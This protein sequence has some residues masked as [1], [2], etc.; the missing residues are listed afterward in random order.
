M[1]RHPLSEPFVSPSQLQMNTESDKDIASLCAI[2]QEMISYILR[3]T[4]FKDK[5]ILAGLQNDILNNALE[6]E[7]VSFYN[8]VYRYLPCGKWF[9]PSETKC[10]DIRLVPE[11]Q[12]L[13]IDLYSNSNR[14]RM[15]FNKKNGIRL[16]RK[17]RPLQ[18][19]K[20]VLYFNKSSYHLDDRRA[21]KK[22]NSVDDTYTHEWNNRRFWKVA[23]YP[24]RRTAS[25]LLFE[26][27]GHITGNQVRIAM[28]PATPTTAADFMTRLQSGD[29]DRFFGRFGN[30][31]HNART[32][33]YRSFYNGVPT[34]V[35]NINIVNFTVSVQH[36]ANLDSD[37]ES[38]EDWEEI[39]YAVEDFKKTPLKRSQISSLPFATKNEIQEQKHLNCTVKC[40][41]TMNGTLYRQLV[42]D[43]L[44]RR[45]Y[46]ILKDFVVVSVFYK[47][48]PVALSAD[49]TCHTFDR[50]IHD[51][52]HEWKSRQQMSTLSYMVDHDPLFYIHEI[53][54]LDT[55]ALPRQCRNV[56]INRSMVDALRNECSDSF[57]EELYHF[58]TLLNFN[59]PKLAPL[60]GFDVM[61]CTRILPQNIRLYAYDYDEINIP[62]TPVGV[63]LEKSFGPVESGVIPVRV[64]RGRLAP[65]TS[66]SRILSL[67]NDHEAELQVKTPYTW[68]FDTLHRTVFPLA[69]NPLENPI[70]V[71]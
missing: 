33:S 54:Q 3:F 6:T 68:H 18:D 23:D 64:L 61:T 59:V 38:D 12:A 53:D 42:I 67:N 55:H 45:K 13:Q 21:V 11:L 24:D 14:K 8:H 34:A 43:L 51:P 32:I 16:V 36:T 4:S 2:P 60:L 41:T 7:V 27:N 29:F 9:R 62:C 46:P 39:I 58:I 48:I 19:G 52:L 15:C 26:E 28:D 44:Y 57:E 49:Q 1:S 50:R 63:S 30:N 25:A 20:H 31:T 65:C 5:L 35:N 37:E 47:Q 22:I 66:A 69:F 56:K 71:L 17:C 70:L 10:Y 40:Y